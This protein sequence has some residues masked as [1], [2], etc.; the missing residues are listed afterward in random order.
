MSE[1]SRVESV[2][3]QHG[4]AELLAR[5][6]WHQGLFDM[7]EGGFTASLDR[8]RLA[9]AGYVRVRDVENQ[10]AIHT[11]LAENLQVLGENHRAWRERNASLALLDEVRT[12]RG[13]HRMLAEASLACQYQRLRRTALHL[14]DALVEAAKGSAD[15]IL[16]ADSLVGRAAVL[17]GL[18]FRDLAARDVADARR[19]VGGIGDPLLREDVGAEIDLTE[20]TILADWEPE[21]ATVLLQHALGYFEPVTPARV[22]ALRLLLGRAQAGRGL[23][24]EAEEQYEAGIAKLEAQG[25]ALREVALQASFF[26]HALPLFDEMVDLEVDRRR[27][28]A[29]AL[30]FLER[31]RARQLADSL[32]GPP[33]PRRSDDPAL[34][35]LPPP[36]DPG[37]LQRELPQGVALVYYVTRESRLL[38]WALT[39]A[40]SRFV[41]R[42]LPA[43]EL[44]RLVAAHEAAI[45]SRAPVSTAHELSGRLY[46][47]LVRPLASVLQDQH[48]L[49]FIPDGVLESVAFASLWDSQSGRY[50]VEDKLVGLVPSGTAFVRATARA[51]EERGDSPPTALVVGNPQLEGPLRLERPSLHGAEAEATEVAGLYQGSELLTGSAATKAEFLRRMQE[52]RIV[53]FAGHAASGDP[54]GSAHLLLAPDE[55]SGDSGALYVRELDRTR[56]SRTAV[57]VLAACRT[58]AGRTPRLAGALNVACP[59]LA[60]GVPNVVA[61]LWDVDDAV[62]RRFFVA[63]HRALLAEGD[64]LLAL[65]RTQIALLRGGDLWLAHPASWAGFVCM[66]GFDSRQP[67]RASRHDAGRRP[68]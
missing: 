44:R 6:R 36:L 18:G 51:V 23:D 37:A 3:A 24:A 64:P 34:R 12:H 33:G 16:V 55:S 41:D 45:W 2:A 47:E 14:E 59:F 43:D 22:P 53:H 48:A 28:P 5:V 49:V 32:A 7:H 35:T 13:R 11:L 50:L 54:P 31:G 62:S 15:A 63:F 57:L 1:A 39:R 42:P 38:S 21:R 68:L 60:A 30:L 46:D 9:L 17:N 26:E 19:V 25:V 27:D 52:S 20:G 65:Q 29:R 61:S 67:G 8:Y 66:G 10:A 58:A 4:Y 40:E 56:F